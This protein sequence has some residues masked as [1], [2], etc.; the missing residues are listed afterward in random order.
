MKI[1]QTYW[2]KPM[3]QTAHELYNR[4]QGG[5]PTMTDSLCA[6]AYSS[7]T[8]NKFY[9]NTELITD[10]FG[11]DLLISKL[12]L[13]YSTVANVLNEF[14]VNLNL[15]AMAKVNTY[16]MQ[17]EPFIHVDNDIFIW[18]KFPEN[19]ESANLCCQNIEELTS[20]YKLAL[21]IIRLNFSKIPSLLNEAVSPNVRRI[22]EIK[23]INAGIIGGHNIPFFKNYSDIVFSLYNDYNKDLLN[24]AEKIGLFNIVLEQLVFGLLANNGNE[25]IEYLMSDCSFDEMINKLA[26]IHTAPIKSKYVHCL[27]E[28]KRRID[29]ASQIELR[30]KY[31]YP[32]YYER[33]GK[34]CK[35][36]GIQM[37][38]RGEYKR[39]ENA[40]KLISQIET[41]D[42]FMNEI[43]FKLKKDVFF[44][45]NEG[46]LFIVCSSGKMELSS[47]SKV[48]FYLD[49]Y[50]T[51]N[52]IVSII[53]PE[54]IEFMSLED[55]EDNIFS[56]LIQ[57]LYNG[58]FLDYKVK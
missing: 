45:E 29:I 5:W 28:L 3:R 57:S 4:I 31:E 7:L 19:I 48:L 12:K 35:S 33:I 41:Q 37:S 54:L 42:S 8:I 11:A 10:D 15:W 44:E 14:D 21:D 17:D 18:S 38:C 56:Y 23:S 6:M 30:L 20:D 53:K 43:F 50:Q 1:V 46:I 16:G 36:I 22:K 34:Y 25:R 39:F 47:W 55:I 58:N 2:T 40:Y 9:K 24:S 26:D 32:D 13:P 27:G 49:K 51:G 52:D